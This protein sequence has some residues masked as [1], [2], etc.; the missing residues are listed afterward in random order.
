LQNKSQ[1]FLHSNKHPK[2]PA[3]QIT[4]AKYY[5]AEAIDY[6]VLFPQAEAYRYRRIY[7]RHVGIVQ[8]PHVLT[9]SLFVDGT[10]L[11]QQDHRILSQSN[12]SACDVDVRW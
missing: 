5:E 12:A 11:L 9:E 8:M 3:K 1:P 2:S 4:S 6:S 10:D 7:L